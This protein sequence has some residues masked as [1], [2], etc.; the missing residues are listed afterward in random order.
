MKFVD[1][2]GRDDL[3]YDQNGKWL[4][5]I[6][7]KSENVYI[8]TD[9]STIL[10]CSKKQ[11][12]D[13]VAA[14][15]GETSLHQ[16][17]ANAISDAIENRANYT[18]RTISDIVANTGIYGYNPGTIKKTKTD[19]EKNQDGKM[20]MARTAVIHSLTSNT[21]VSNASY[22]WEGLKFIDPQSRFYNKNNFYV[23]NGWGVTPGIDGKI[24]FN[25]V[26]RIGGTVF[27]INNPEVRKKCYP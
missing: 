8:R 18:N 4:E 14:V 17:E 1:P 25:E 23:R 16:E 21:D 7:S 6:K 24:R 13:Y 27:M 15:Y 22:F 20:L 10:L 12:I 26:K 2:T 19:L 11:Y 9:D 3:Y 5:T